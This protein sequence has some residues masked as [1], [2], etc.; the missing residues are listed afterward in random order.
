[1]D[2]KQRRSQSHH[3][4]QGLTAHGV[5]FWLLGEGLR[6]SSGDAEV[7]LV[8]FSHQYRKYYGNVMCCVE[9]TFNNNC[10]RGL[11]AI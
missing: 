5:V 6:Q 10:G 7:G 9:M 8:P 2:T 3:V 4:G 1:M 11:L